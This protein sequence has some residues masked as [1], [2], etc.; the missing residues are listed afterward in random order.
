M[1]EPPVQPVLHRD[2]SERRSR[3]VAH[4]GTLCYA[5]AAV[6]YLSI[7]LA[8]IAMAFVDEEL[9]HPFGW[10]LGLAMAVV[11]AGTSMLVGMRGRRGQL[12]PRQAD[13]VGWG[14]TLSVLNWILVFI[15]WGIALS[16]WPH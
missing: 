8:P 14:I 5:L 3:R 9:V 6:A 4:A 16:R 12:T 11:F 2:E 7:F 1:P 13:L 15:V 10:A